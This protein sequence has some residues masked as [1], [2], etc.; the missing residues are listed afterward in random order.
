[1]ES[2]AHTCA[3]LSILTSQSGYSYLSGKGKDQYPSLITPVHVDV[4]V[5]VR[6]IGRMHTLS[7]YSSHTAALLHHFKGCT[8][9]SVNLIILWDGSLLLV[10]SWTRTKPAI[11][12]PVGEADIDTAG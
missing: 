5:C 2:R 4:I 12:Q 10:S 3:H 7:V 1:M 6:Q 8:I 11:R 9:L